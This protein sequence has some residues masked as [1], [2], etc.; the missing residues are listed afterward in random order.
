MILYMYLLQQGEW[1]IIII[2]LYT[3]VVQCQYEN[4]LIKLT[5]LK[6]KKLVFLK[7]QK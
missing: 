2:E 3:V 7:K 4:Y 5:L 1:F 6:G